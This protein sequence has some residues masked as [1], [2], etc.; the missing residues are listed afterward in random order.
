MTDAKRPPVDIQVARPEDVPTCI[1]L[2]EAVIGGRRGG[3]LVQA[4][5]D[6][7]QLLVAAA[8]GEVVGTLAYRTDWFACTFVTLVSVRPDRRRRGV[9]RALYQAVEEWSPSARLFSSAEETNVAAIHF[10]R[11]LGFVISG[12][13]DNLPQGYRELLFYKRLTS[14]LRATH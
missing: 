11:A 1:D 14:T 10:H 2:A 13:V 12:Y 8:D 7:Q 3:P 4:A 5:V 6:R 9:A